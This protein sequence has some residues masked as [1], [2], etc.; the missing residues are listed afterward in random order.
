MPVMKS[1]DHSMTIRALNIE[2]ILKA[3]ISANTLILAAQA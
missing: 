2:N 3:K 1:P